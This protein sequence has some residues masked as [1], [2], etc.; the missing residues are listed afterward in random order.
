MRPDKYLDVRIVRT[1]SVNE[2]LEDCDAVFR[3]IAFAAKRRYGEPVR[4]AIGEIKLAVGIE[5]FVLGVLQAGSRGT[6]HAVV[7]APGGR[8]LFQPSYPHEIFEFGLAHG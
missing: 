7:F 6:Q 5:A 8:L 4:R 1:Q 3:P 2:R